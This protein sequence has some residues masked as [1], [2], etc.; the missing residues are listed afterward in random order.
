MSSASSAVCDQ[1][2]AL[3]LLHRTWL[4]RWLRRRLGCSETSADLA[5]DT[6]VRLLRKPTAAP[7]RKPRAYL[8]TIAHGLAVNHLRRR[9]VEQAYLAALAARPEQLAPS[10]EESE[11]AIEALTKLVGALEGLPQRAC[12]V[13]LLSQMEGLAYRQIAECLGITVNVVQKDMI[14]AMKCC[15]GAIYD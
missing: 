5:Q 3:Y 13:F 10:P 6:F 8:R 14:K 15:Y 2:E 7:V 9:D 1:T 4:V 12:E 11:L